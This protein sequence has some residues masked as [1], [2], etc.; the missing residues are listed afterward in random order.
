MTY[1]YLK[2]KM[3]NI[4]EAE[5]IF[6]YIIPQLLK[7]GWDH[8][9]IQI[10]RSYHDIRIS[11]GEF[12]IE[13]KRFGALSNTN[14]KP[15]RSGVLQLREYLLE[16]GLTNGCLTDGQSWYYV[17]LDSIH[18]MENRLDEISKSSIWSNHSI[19]SA[20]TIAMTVE[21]QPL[22]SPNRSIKTTVPIGYTLTKIEINNLL[23]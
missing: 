7:L 10:G 2:N 15:Y 9:D 17:T 14:N 11:N 20:N 8:E 21:D 23:L 5:T 1:F 22:D 18:K 6:S 19:R 13:A 12:I 3:K 16:S 4:N